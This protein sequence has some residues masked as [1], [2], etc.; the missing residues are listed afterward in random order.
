M[1]GFKSFFSVSFCITCKFF[2]F[3]TCKIEYWTRN[4]TGETDIKH[5]SNHA[6]WRPQHLF[7]DLTLNNS[8]NVTRPSSHSLFSILLIVETAGSKEI[9][10]FGTLFGHMHVI[11][12]QIFSFN[13]CNALKIHHTSQN[14]IKRTFKGLVIIRETYYPKKQ[15]NMYIFLCFIQLHL[16]QLI[17]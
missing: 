8:F 5:K 6:I 1:I 13:H 11:T 14:V 7:P 4:D 12:N 10:I 3:K 15:T 17:C 2:W 16:M 9:N